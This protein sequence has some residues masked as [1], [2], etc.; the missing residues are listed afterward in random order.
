MNARP[1]EDL[2]LP[3]GEAGTVLAVRGTGGI[4]KGPGGPLVLRYDAGTTGDEWGGE[5][6]KGG[7]TSGRMRLAG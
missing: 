3:I 7:R 2:E 5:E 1:M 4:V 6:G